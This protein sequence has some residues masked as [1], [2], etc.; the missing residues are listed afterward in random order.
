MKFTILPAVLA[1]LP[2][3]VDAVIIT[4]SNFDGIRAGQAFEITWDEALGPVSITLKEGNADNLQTVAELTSNQTGDSYT[5]VP[6]S[7][8]PTGT[9]ALEIND[10]TDVNYSEQFQV[11]GGAASSTAGTSS[12]SASRTSASASSTAT[13]SSAAFSTTSSI[14]TTSSVASTESVSSESASVTSQATESSASSTLSTSTSSASRT[15]STGIPATESPI[16]NT[17]AAQS[18][19]PLVAPMLLALGAALI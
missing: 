4:N 19:A 5:W 12:A 8:L 18:V 17:N 1:A 6:S 11:Q 15:T 10:G 9:Y 13:E 16:P 2:G 14:A 3:L 7:S